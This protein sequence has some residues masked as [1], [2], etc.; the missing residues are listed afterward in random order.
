MPKTP[1]EAKKLKGT[2][3]PCRDV[4]G[5]TRVPGEP[6]KPYMM[7]AGPSEVWAKTVKL[8]LDAGYLAKTDGM[9]LAVYCELAFEF[10]VA[11]AEMVCAKLAQLRMVM[12]DLGLSPSAR[13]KIPVPKKKEE[14]N[15]SSFMN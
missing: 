4:S 7:G 2:Y 14:N 10:S 6:V 5:E 1:S 13:A 9:V 11:P 3:Q 15:F 8:L 12:N